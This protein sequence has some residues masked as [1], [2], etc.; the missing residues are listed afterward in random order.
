M[1]EYFLLDF[2]SMENAARASKCWYK[3][4]STLLNLACAKNEKNE[5]A[6]A[7]VDENGN[8]Q[9]TFF[10]S[11]PENPDGWAEVELPSERTKPY[12]Y[13]AP[14]DGKKWVLHPDGS[15]YLR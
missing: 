10:M 14:A 11:G 9:H 4:I 6:L 5:V 8:Y 7:V 13:K 1:A 3:A 2:E 12:L 15:W